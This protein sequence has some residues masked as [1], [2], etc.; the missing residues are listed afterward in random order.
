MTAQ[1]TFP[2]PSRFENGEYNE[3]EIAAEFAE[4][5]KDIDALLSTFVN[6]P[7]ASLDRLSLEDKVGE[8]TARH[9]AQKV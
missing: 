7:H 2:D 8:I 4:T 3:A 9:A 6:L 1:W 5:Y